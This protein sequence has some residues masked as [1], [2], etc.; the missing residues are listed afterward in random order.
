MQINVLASG[1]SGN[2]YKITA[3][4]HSILIELGIPWKKILQGIKFN[5][6]GLDFAIIS[7]APHQDHCKATKDAI[8]AGIDV[9]MSRESAIVLGIQD[10]HRVIIVEPEVQKTIGSWTILPFSA[11]HDVPCLA[12]V[13]AYKNER[14]LYMTDSAY[15]K[16]RFSGLTHIMVEANFNEDILSSNILNGNLN[17]FAGHR[18]RRTHMSLEVLIE[19]LRAN[20]LSKCERIYLLHLSNAN[21][22]SVRMVREVQEATGIPTEAC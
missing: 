2:C 7:H 16:P 9:V 12:F 21:S 4:N 6:S 19:M 15:A 18:I 22:D 20:D 17:A 11:I 13:I 3:E 8:H 14:L 5:S 1:S 10:H